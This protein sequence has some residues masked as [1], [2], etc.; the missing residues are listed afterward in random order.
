MR[1]LLVGS[2]GREH[3]LAWKI[4]KSPLVKELYI[5]PGNG[6]TEKHGK[7]VPIEADNIPELVKFAQEKKINLVVVG[8]ELPLVLGLKNALE[9]VGIDCF[10]PGAFAAQLEGSK[11]FAKK[12]MHKTSVPTAAFE[13]FEDYQ[14]ALAY[15]KN[16]SFPVVIKADGLA[17]GKGVVIAQNL[18][19]AN[20]TLQQIMEEKIFGAAGKR[21]VIEEALQGEEASFLAFCDG[22][23]V[24][25]LPSSQDHKRIGEKDTG[26]NTGGMGAYSPAPILPD[27]D[28]QKVGDMV[29]KPI[30]EHLAEMGHPFK[31][32]LYAGLML[33]AEGP[34]VLEYNVRFG[35]PEC[36]PLLMR[37]ENDLVE[38]MLACVKGELDKVELKINPKSTLCV[39]MAAQG[40]PGKYPKGMEIKGL[41]EVEKDPE[42]MVF[43][44]GT[45]QKD[46]KYYTS[47]GRVLGVTALGKT[48]MEAKEKAYQAV[49][50]IYFDNMYYRRDIGDKGIAKL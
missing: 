1:I 45:T 48:L 3:A 9:E 27:K 14:E 47:G 18:E 43:H 23:R 10:G 46:G 19:E 50:K 37:L 32:I 11:A 16:K 26:P 20:T 29:I 13:V 5:T 17:A 12:I 44:A 4:A 30:I 38:V 36:Q 34:K 39:V 25:Y 2:G 42:V 33:T 31:G 6:G 24:K 22:Q 7:N 21:V 8:P 15:I 41:E 35:D 28:M 49:D 40:Y